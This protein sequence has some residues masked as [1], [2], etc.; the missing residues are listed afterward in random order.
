MA[1]AELA[2]AELTAMPQPSLTDEQRQQILAAAGTLIRAAVMAQTPSLADATLAGAASTP[3]AGAFV[4]LKR[5][6]HLRSCCGGL[7]EQVVPLGKALQDAAWRTALDDVRFPPVSP[8]EFEHLEMEVWVLFNPRQVQERGEDRVQA[9]T[10]GGKHGLLVSRGQARGLLLPGVAVE[11][12]WDSR[13]FLNQVCVKAGLHPTLWQDDET[14]LL[15][16]EGISF[17]GPI[18]DLESLAPI[19]PAPLFQPQEMAAY[20]SFCR[21]NLLLL[22][23]GATPNYYLFGTPDGQVNGIVLLVQ[24]PRSSQL[25]A[26]TQLSL[27]PGIPLQST[28]FSLAQGAAQALVQQ[29]ITAQELP[30]L[31]VGVAIL[32]DPAMHGTMG[33][34]HLAGI[35]PAQ[36]AVL[37]M[38]RGKSGLV[39]DPQRCP[40][41]LL[42]EGARL[43]RVRQPASAGVF[44]L[45]AVSTATRLAV[46]T[47]P[48]PLAGPAVR[49]PGVAGRFYPAEPEKLAELVDTLMEGERRP[50][51]WAAAMVPHAGLVYSGKLAAAVFRRL[52]I[53][54]TVIV[55]GPKHTNQGVEWAVAPH[56]RWLFPG[57]SLASDP[58]LARQLAQGIPGLELDAL[59]HQSEHAI[60]VEL[61]LLAR[62]APKTHVVG[63]ALGGGDLDSCR[64]F[65]R[66]LAEVVQGLPQ[67]PLLL[68]SSDMNHFATD[69]ENRRL[70]AMALAALARLDPEELYETVTRN[71]ISM[72][73]VLP[74]VIVMETLRLLAG[75]SKAEQVGYATSADVTG[76]TS[77]V[78]GYAGMLFG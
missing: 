16:F 18:A 10:V 23:T 32:H 50:E 77:R 37:V 63:I 74:A 67:R 38:E 33:D 13:Q 62:L 5:Q 55:L 21:D 43:A 26:L 58:E 52:Q 68:I 56:Q 9:V 25:L 70:D 64:Q 42:E 7:L 1:S 49:P 30:G 71:N 41:E 61:P 53:P 66:K 47:G 27:R 29:G 36:R 28:L 65:A 4:S 35:D 19:V 48:Q 59:A 69:R 20:A 22:L 8:S 24:R 2:V 6:G 46:A 39:F 34:P 60:E 40:E 3:V 57:G 51:P 17:R 73:G 44:S 76:D 45:A 54:D 75:L 11:H 78:V 15:T 14:S 31:Q 72:C 12:D